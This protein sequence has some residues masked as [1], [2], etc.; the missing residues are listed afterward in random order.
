MRHQSQNKTLEQALSV[1]IYSVNVPKAVNARSS[2]HV[3]L[4]MELQSTTIGCRM[5]TTRISSEKLKG[6]N[7]A[8]I[9]ALFLENKLAFIWS[10]SP[11][12]SSE[13]ARYP[14]S[15]TYYGRNL[16]SDASASGNRR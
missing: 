15:K 9:I 4:V 12:S 11:N 1:I 3:N 7:M 13:R 16:P 8:E 10:A 14:Q 6:N 5:A 2:V